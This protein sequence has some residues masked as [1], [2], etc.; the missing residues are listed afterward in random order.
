MMLDL[1]GKAKGA[2]GVTRRNPQAEAEEM[3]LKT[4]SNP[5]HLT[6]ELVRRVKAKAKERDQRILSNALPV[7][8]KAFP[9]IMLSSLALIGNSNKL[10]SLPS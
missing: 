1:R 10:K 8:V 4:H 2:K 7:L 3:R 9:Q 6:R 5:A